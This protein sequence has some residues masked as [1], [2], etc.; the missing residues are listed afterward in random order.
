MSRAHRHLLGAAATLLSVGASACRC[1]RGEPA[2]TDAQA[3][4]GPLVESSWLVELQ[5]P[6]HA[7]AQVAVPLGSIEP[8]PVVIAL[9]GGSDRPE[10]QCGTWAGVTAG[11][12]FIVCPTGVPAPTPGRYTFA[13]LDRTEREV[14]A[15]LDAA[16]RRWGWRIAGRSVV[17]AGYGLGAEHAAL[18]QRREPAFF[19]SL[20][21]IDGGAASWNP[22]VAAAFVH[23]GGRRVWFGCTRAECE[24]VVERAKLFTVRAGGDARAV[25]SRADGGLLGAATRA[26][27]RA[28]WDWISAE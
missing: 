26:A 18:L 6:E 19:S 16:K 23:R 1:D 15:A 20:V 7:P 3:A 4:L 2:T 10:W 28:D 11:A 21:L 17:L 24:P 12:P 25:S 9:H 5:V 8:R 27:L 13:A 14:R 22:T